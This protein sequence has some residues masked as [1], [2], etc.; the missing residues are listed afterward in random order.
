MRVPCPRGLGPGH[1]RPSHL[2]PKPGLYIADIPRAGASVTLTC[3]IRSSCIEARARFLSW[4]EP[5]MS[6]STNGSESSSVSSSVLHFTPRP[7]DHGAALQCHLNFSLSNSTA[8]QFSMISECWWAK[9]APECERN[10]NPK[11]NSPRP[12][13][14]G[15]DLLGAVPSSPWPLGLKGQR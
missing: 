10:D 8:V 4:K 6:F 11:R 13:G 14:K 9:E 5:A 7:K 2:T 3:T 12:H 1:L 15:R